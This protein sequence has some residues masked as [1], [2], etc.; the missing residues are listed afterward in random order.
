MSTY[1]P[2]PNTWTLF[3]NTRKT[4]DTQPDYTGSAF[5]EMP[6]GTPKEF[7]LSAWKRVSKSDV[8]FIGGFI[9]PKEDPAPKL[10]DESAAA[11]AGDQDPW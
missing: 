1:Q 5:L 11:G 10:L 6:D 2:K 7:R 4:N 8:K 3:Q 9:K